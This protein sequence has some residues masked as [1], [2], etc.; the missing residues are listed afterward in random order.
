MKNSKEACL[1]CGHEMKQN[2]LKEVLN[3]DS[4]CGS[5]VSSRCN[6]DKTKYVDVCMSKNATAQSMSNKK[7]NTIYDYS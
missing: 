4:L 1:Y 2:R 7:L 3:T 6:A 5:I